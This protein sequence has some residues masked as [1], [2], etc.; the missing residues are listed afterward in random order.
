MM[1]KQQQEIELARTESTAKSAA[2][3]VVLTVAAAFTFIMML[4]GYS[5]EYKV[6]GVVSMLQFALIVVAILTKA[7]AK[8]EKSKRL[9]IASNVCTIA[10]ALLV[11]PWFIGMAMPSDDSNK[12]TYLDDIYARDYYWP[13][14]GYAAAMPRYRDQPD[15]SYV[16]DREAKATLLNMTEDDYNAYIEQCKKDGFDIDV[17]AKNKEYNAYNADD[18][19]INVNYISGEKTVVYCVITRIELSS[20][21]K[22][23][24]REDYSAFMTVSDVSEIVGKHIKSTSA[25]KRSALPDD[26]TATVETYPPENAPQTA[27]EEDSEA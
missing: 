2:T 18:Q 27:G 9:V 14:E 8:E 3:Y 26:T 15:Y 23:V 17:T 1:A 11:I 22:L 19:E 13:K 12:K 24:E 6:V 5:T 16:G 25:L 7:I 10:A 21:R 4:F 20:L